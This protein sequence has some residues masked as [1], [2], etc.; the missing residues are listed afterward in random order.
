MMYLNDGTLKHCKEN[1]SLYFL[2]G[3]TLVFSLVCLTDS[4]FNVFSMEKE[5]KMLGLISKACLKR[6]LY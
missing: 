3:L 2:K 5:A 4:M 6:L 1:F